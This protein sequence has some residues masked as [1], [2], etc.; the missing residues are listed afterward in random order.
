M[1]KQKEEERRKRVSKIEDFK[2]SVNYLERQNKRV[3]LLIYCI[4]FLS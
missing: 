2:D 3:Y 1:L 4:I